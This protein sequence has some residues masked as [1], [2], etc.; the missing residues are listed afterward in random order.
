MGT[1]EDTRGGARDHGRPMRVRLREGRSRLAGLSSYLGTLAIPV[2]II[3]AVGH[4]AGL[5]DATSTYAAMALGF[6]L[7]AASVIAALAAFVAI[8]RDGS[9]GTGTALRGLFIGLAILV[10]PAIGAWDVVTLPRL[11]DISTDPSNPPLFVAALR[12]RRPGDAPIVEPDTA[13]AALQRQAYPDIVPRHYPVS[14][15]RVYL[16][17]RNIVDQRGWRVLTDSAPSDDDPSGSIE[18]VAQTLVFGFRQDVAIR[19]VPEGD[20]TRVDM[21]SAARGGAHD[22][23]SDAERVRHFF[24]DLD[25][26]LQGVTGS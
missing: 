23:G 18:A 10:M 5:L 16:E 20:G 22:L 21:R 8:W 14:A 6:A 9:R 1:G 25:N 17:A 4:R 26:A 3:V 2:L 11:T 15:A 19:V 7:A 13:E 24:G 12:D